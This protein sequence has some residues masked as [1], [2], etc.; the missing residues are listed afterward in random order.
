MS[1]PAINETTAYET[2]I[3][4]ALQNFGIKDPKE[5]KSA[6]KVDPKNIY[7]NH[8]WVGKPGYPV[9]DNT[10]KYPALEEHEYVDKAL[11]ADPEIK[12]LLADVKKRTDLTVEIGTEL[13]GV[14]LSKLS[15]KQK[16][17]LALLVA[18]RGVVFFREQDI[19]IEQLLEFGRY[20]G[21]LHIHQTTGQPEGLPEVHVVYANAGLAKVDNAAAPAA[22]SAAPAKKTNPDDIVEYARDLAAKDFVHTDV[23]YEIQPPSYTFLKLDHIPPTGGDTLWFSSYAAYEKLSPT[24]KKFLE[25]L[26]AIHSGVRQAEDS[27]RRGGP[28]RRE[29]VE[30]EH[31]VVRTHPVTGRKALYVNPVFT[32]RIPQLSAHESQLVLNYLYQH[33]QTG[34]D[35]TVRFKWSTNSIALWDNR[36][37][38]HAATFDFGTNYIRHGQRVTPQ[39]EK[40]FFDA[41]YVAKNR[42]AA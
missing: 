33:I 16:D 7:P 42:L 24:F 11:N 38:N 36:V 4:D 5:V 3:E 8:R 14:Q 2:R 31:P 29:P 12:A 6:V 37:T 30:T 19:E 13:E 18:E 28:N 26:T 10:V 41:N 22:E 35:F 25:G 32:R 21:R 23:S 39:A 40:P 9:F 1:P 27:I 34:Y 20:Y 15:D 17:E